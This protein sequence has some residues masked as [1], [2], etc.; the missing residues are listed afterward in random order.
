M[1]FSDFF[2]GFFDGFEG[3]RRDP[4]DPFRGWE[5]QGD[6]L[7]R[8]R[9]PAPGA[10]SKRSHFSNALQSYIQ[11]PGNRTCYRLIS[12]MY[13]DPE[14]R[15]LLA[16]PLI[17]SKPYGSFIFPPLVWAI[18]NNNYEA[19]RMLLETGYSN[20]AWRDDVGRTALHYAQES[21]NRDL[22]NL[23]QQ[24][25]NE[26]RRGGRKTKKRSIIKKRTTKSH[27]KSKRGTR[28]L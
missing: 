18:K 10:P 12:A 15:D 27:Y 14:T 19:A 13:K 3:V 6:R 11:Y 28:R 4:F 9:S 8:T 23:I 5:I 16:T 26:G 24:A 25:I 20:L 7:V 17:I 22:I 1:S 2:V 21:G